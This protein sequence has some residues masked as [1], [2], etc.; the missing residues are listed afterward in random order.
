MTSPSDSKGGRHS[1]HADSTADALPDR[2][3]LL[4]TSVNHFLGSKHS[5]NSPGMTESEISSIPSPSQCQFRSGAKS[6]GFGA[7]SCMGI[8]SEPMY[9]P[10]HHSAAGRLGGGGSFLTA[11]TASSLLPN[12]NPGLS[13][14]TPSTACRLAAHSSSDYSLRQPSSTPPSSSSS[15]YGLRPNPGQAHHDTLSSCTY[16][17]SSQHGYAPHHF[18]ANMHVMNMNFP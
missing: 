1:P 3:D 18:A 4:A 5:S 17:N 16:M 2:G 11:A 8:S 14:S 6:D 15:S 13:M 12:M 7:V 10:Y 9:Y